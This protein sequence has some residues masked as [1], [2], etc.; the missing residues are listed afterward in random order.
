MSLKTQRIIAG[1]GA[2]FFALQFWAF[3]RLVRSRNL[4]PGWSVLSSA[5][6]GHIG[7]VLFFSMLLTIGVVGF[8]IW[9]DEHV[10]REIRRRV[11]EELHRYNS[12]S[13]EISRLRRLLKGVAV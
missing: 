1:L 4:D 12:S 11:D 2:L 9:V 5:A 8:L 7:V 13:A 6:V 3:I 10:E